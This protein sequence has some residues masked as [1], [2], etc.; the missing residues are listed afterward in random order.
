MSQNTYLLISMNINGYPPR[1]VVRRGLQEGRGRGQL[2]RGGA[3]GRQLFGASATPP[4][5]K[6][7]IADFAKAS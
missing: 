4:C 6:G 1:G 7:H 5:Y 3:R 2:W